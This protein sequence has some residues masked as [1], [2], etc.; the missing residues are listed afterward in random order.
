VR[1][2]AEFAKKL[3]IQ[4]VGIGHCVDMQREADLTARYL[5]THSLEALLPPM[6]PECD[7]IGQAEFFAENGIKLNAIC[8]MSVDHEAIFIAASE[9]PVVVL[10]ARDVRLR[11]NPVAALYTSAGYSRTRLFG[12]RDTAVW[13]PFQGLGMETLVR[14]SE[15]L[16]AEGPH[17]LNRVQ[18]VLRYARRLGIKRL[19]ISF[20]V[21]FKQEARLLAGVLKGN[22]FEVSSAG[23]K[24]GAVPKEKLG[25]VESEKVHPGDPEMICNPLAQAE[26]LNRDGVQ[27]SLILGQCIG[28]EAATLGALKMPAVC[29]VAKDRVLAHNPVAALYEFEGSG[30][31]AT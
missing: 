31:T 14:A 30:P 20:C 7:P 19:G 10:V 21:G 4:R 22:G 18:E 1:E 13:E 24:V 12:D 8:G 23:C 16:A 3:G 9:K 5:E 28:H 27:L 25:I 26:L 11:H 15:A 29:I 17:D 6:P 2:L